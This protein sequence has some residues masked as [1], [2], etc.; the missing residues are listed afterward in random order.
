MLRGSFPTDSFEGLKTPFYYYDTAL[1]KRT[2][3]VVRS[4][5]SSNPNWRVH[6]AVK[7]NFNPAILRIAQAIGANAVLVPTIGLSDGIINQL[8]NRNS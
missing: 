2:L 4:Y 3:E 7:A 5:L 6:Y 1:L 8:A